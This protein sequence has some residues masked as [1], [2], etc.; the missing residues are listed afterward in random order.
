MTFW[1]HVVM[2]FWAMVLSIALLASI[3]LFDLAGLRVLIFLSASWVVTLLAGTAV[4]LLVEEL[5][6]S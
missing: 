3:I 6:D 5:D 4:F 2:I 1:F